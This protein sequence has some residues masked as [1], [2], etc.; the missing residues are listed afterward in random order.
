M[1]YIGADAKELGAGGK[2]LLLNPKTHEKL[3]DLDTPRLVSD[4]TELNGQVYA[5]MPGHLAIWNEPLC[6]HP[7][8]I[9]K[10]DPNPLMFALYEKELWWGTYWGEIRNS[11]NIKI[12]GVKKYMGSIAVGPNYLYGGYEDQKCR[13]FKRSGGRGKTLLTGMG[14]PK[15]ASNRHYLVSSDKQGHIS[16][17]DHASLEKLNEFNVDVGSAK[18]GVIRLRVFDD[19]IIIHTYKK[20]VI[21]TTEGTPLLT[22]NSP[23]EASINDCW[24]REH[25]ILV[26]CTSELICIRVR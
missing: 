21:V 25:D 19:V 7:P 13:A 9:T 4:I 6:T 20:L 16:F 24:L 3:C 8:N 5:G 1:I 10:I 26:A 23:P 15:L 17:W 14:Q 2:L 18:W 11:C 12:A 22:W